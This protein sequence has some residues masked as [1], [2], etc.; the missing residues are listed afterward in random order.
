MMIAIPKIP[1]P[2]QEL[3]LL[4]SSHSRYTKVRNSTFHTQN[5]I[6]FLE[7]ENYSI[8]LQILINQTKR[9]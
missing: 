9:I 6:L 5:L 1:L 7:S 8:E 2:I 3:T 4:L